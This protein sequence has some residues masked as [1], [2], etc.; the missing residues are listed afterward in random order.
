MTIRKEIDEHLRAELQ[1]IIAKNAKN[2]IYNSKLIGCTRDELWEKYVSRDYFD[3]NF[4]KD[5]HVSEKNNMINFKNMRMSEKLLRVVEKIYPGKTVKVSGNFHYPETGYMMWHT[6]S[7]APCVR[8]YVT[9]AN[10]A[11]KSFFRYIDPK[12]NETITDYD[13]E[14]ITIREFSITDKPPYLWHAVGSNCDRL[15]FGYR[16]F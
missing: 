14:G 1:S 5:V 4:N 11:N 9:W 10:L 6:N 2:I 15:S 16:I 7:D 13:D 12:T 3:A 8:L